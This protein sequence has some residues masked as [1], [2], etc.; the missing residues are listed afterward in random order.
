[1]Q[2]LEFQSN[3]AQEENPALSVIWTPQKKS[4]S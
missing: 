1:M 4:G 3:E 2:D